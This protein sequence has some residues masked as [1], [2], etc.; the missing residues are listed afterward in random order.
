MLYDGLLLAALL[1]FASLIVVVPFGITLEH[2]LYPI[3]AA[4]IYVISFAFFGWFWT[5]GGQTLGMQTWRF[6]IEEDNG[7]AITWRHALL[8]F[9]AA[10]V[11]WLPFGAGFIWCLFSTDRLTFHD[12]VSGTHLVRTD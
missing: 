11:S 10:C 8:R 2:P 3:Y 12:A 1:F 5:H 6:R 7:E 9:L 4:Y